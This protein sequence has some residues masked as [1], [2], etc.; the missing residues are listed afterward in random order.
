MSVVDFL[1]QR[2]NLVKVHFPMIE[3][4]AA[5][6]NASEYFF[7]V[8]QNL[9]NPSPVLEAPAGSWFL[10]DNIT[11][12]LA[13][14]ATE[15]MY[16]EAVIPKPT[17]A[18]QVARPLAARFFWGD[19]QGGNAQVFASVPLVRYYTAF[20]LRLW[21]RSPSNT[22]TNP[23]RLDLTGGLDT[24]NWSDFSPPDYMTVRLTAR[25]FEIQDRAFNERLD[26]QG[27]GGLG[28]PDEGARG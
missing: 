19:V 12:R 21:A 26:T 3:V 5:R 13:P 2:P 6:V 1:R 23:L 8:G 18:D 22:G 14:Q 24:S 17:Y 9:V 20:P 16:S 25:I 10:I 27:I 28:V 15:E 11:W 4:S 7:T